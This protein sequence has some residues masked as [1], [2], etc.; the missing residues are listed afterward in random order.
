MKGLLATR[1]EGLKAAS[2]RSQARP[3]SAMQMSSTRPLS[4][5]SLMTCLGLQGIEFNVSNSS[6]GDWEGLT[7]EGGSLGRI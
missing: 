3:T 2:A 6:A 1:M 4:L 7:Y 5:Q